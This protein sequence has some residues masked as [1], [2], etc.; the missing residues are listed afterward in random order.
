MGGAGL[1]GLVLAWHL[2]EQTRIEGTSATL[3]TLEGIMSF[4]TAAVALGALAL[5][6]EWVAARGAAEQESIGRLAVK[7]V[8]ATTAFFGLLGAFYYG[9][10]TLRWHV[11]RHNNMI[12]TTAYHLFAESVADIEAA[13]WAAHGH[14]APLGPP[15]WITDLY[16]AGTDAA[17]A[18]P[19]RPDIVFIMLDTLRADALAAYGGDPEWMPRL[20]ALAEDATVF[21][22]VLANAPW[23]QPSVASFFTGLAPEEHGV[24][25]FRYRMSSAALTLAEVLQSQ[26]Y[27]TAAFIATSVIVGPDSGF[28]RGFDT[29]EYLE[30]PEQTYARADTVTNTV[31]EWLAERRATPDPE[32]ATTKPPLFLYVHYFDPH[33]PYLSSDSLDAERGVVTISEAQGFYEDELRFLDRELDRVVGNLNAELPGPRVL[34]VTSDH[35]E[36]FG[37]HDGRGHS[38]TLYS[39]VLDIPAVLQISASAGG[40]IDAELEGLDFFDL[41]LRLGSGETLDVGAWASATERESR[42]A[43]L[44]FE[45]DPGRSELIHYLLRPYRDRIYNRM[46]QRGDWRYIWSAFGRTDELYDL[47][48]DPLERRNVARRQPELVASLKAELDEI[49]PYWTQLVPIRLSEETL[50]Q[51]R[52]LGYI[53]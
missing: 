38:Q 8:A 39:E 5:L 33:V 10:N 34:F 14:G 18:S 51:L 47:S 20:N 12:G 6:L 42:V 9:S 50:Q 11:L 7:W 24:V 1:L 28:S 46:I 35:G 2:R 43:S 19:A 17:A 25:F 36:E 22:E 27:E 26:G 29:F 13:D 52:Q 40:V 48:T 23:T 31:T 44:Q 3:W 41:L 30:D 21:T 37:E 15:S 53:R 16:V 49:P 32:V 45:K 4:L